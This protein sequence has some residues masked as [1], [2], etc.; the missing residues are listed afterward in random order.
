[1]GLVNHS[2]TLNNLI[3]IKKNDILELQNVIRKYNTNRDSLKS[4][5]CILQDNQKHE[6]QK[7]YSP[8]Y[9][10]ILNDYISSTDSLNTDLLNKI[11]DINNKLALVQD[12]LLKHFTELK[13]YETLLANNIQIQIEQEKKSEQSSLDEYYIQNH[14]DKDKK[15]DLG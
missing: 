3:K 7:Y 14:A 10:P 2:N 15:H 11:A 1:M 8:E 9:L 5:L 12:E 4:Q 13:Q 6:I